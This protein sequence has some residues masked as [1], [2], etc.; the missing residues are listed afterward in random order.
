MVVM[1]SPPCKSELEQLSVADRLQ[2]M[3]EIWESLAPSPDSIPVPDWHVA[4][5]RRRLTA[6]E[7]DG[8]RGRPADEVLA[9]LKQRL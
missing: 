1:A 2:L 3:D 4:E 8:D 6:L 9:D 5:N 7:T